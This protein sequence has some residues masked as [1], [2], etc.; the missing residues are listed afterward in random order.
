MYSGVMHLF[1]SFVNIQPKLTAALLHGWGVLVWMCN[2][3]SEVQCLSPR[4]CVS[5]RFI[6]QTCKAYILLHLNP[7]QVARP[8]PPQSNQPTTFEGIFLTYSLQSERKI[9]FQDCSEGHGQKDG[10]LSSAQGGGP[11]GAWNQPPQRVVICWSKSGCIMAVSLYTDWRDAFWDWLEVLGYAPKIKEWIS[12]STCSLILPISVD[13]SANITL[14]TCQIRAQDSQL[15]WCFFYHY[16]PLASSFVYFFKK[17][18]LS[19][20]THFFLISKWSI[21]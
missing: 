12:P 4:S 6:K 1:H 10:I 7:C 19:H 8:L 15:V 11:W 13:W 17:K 20:K 21:I 9:T 16:I 3:P 5:C 14:V 2:P 18:I